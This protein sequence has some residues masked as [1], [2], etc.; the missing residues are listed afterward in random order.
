MLHNQ[1]IS[2]EKGSCT[3]DCSL[4]IL[5]WEVEVVFDSRN[6]VP[7]QVDKIKMY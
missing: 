1:V 7:I 2:L 5:S 6:F 3:V 4:N